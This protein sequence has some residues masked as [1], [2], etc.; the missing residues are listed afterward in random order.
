MAQALQGV[1]VLSDHSETG[2]V[3]S[4][5]GTP[6]V[7]IVST[8][9]SVPARPSEKPEINLYHFA[10]IS[11]PIAIQKST[12]DGLDFHTCLSLSWASL[13]SE[14]SIKSSGRQYRIHWFRGPP[15]PSPNSGTSLPQS[16]IPL[17]FLRLMLCV[18]ALHCKYFC[19]SKHPNLTS[20]PAMFFSSLCLIFLLRVSPQILRDGVDSRFTIRSSA[21]S[22]RDC[23]YLA[24]VLTT[25]QNSSHQRQ[26]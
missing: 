17:L 10:Y 11:S 1:T 15:F 18:G 7:I 12:G 26:P 3:N 21:S 25:L 6:R 2:S 23:R 4:G 8:A 14:G 5:P 22:F 19:L 20:L 13:K 16:S 24:S 9:R